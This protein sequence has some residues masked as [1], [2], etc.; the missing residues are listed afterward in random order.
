MVRHRF[1]Y[2][3]RSDGNDATPP[4][5]QHGR[6]D[7]LSDID[8]APQLGSICFVPALL[9]CLVDSITKRNWGTPGIENEDVQTAKFTFYRRCKAVDIGAYEHTPSNGQHLYAL[10][11]LDFTSYCLQFLRRACKQDDIHA[12]GRQR[13][14]DVLTHAIA[15][16]G[17]QG[18]LALDCEVHERTTT[19]SP[20]TLNWCGM[21]SETHSI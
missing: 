2:G 17:D 1:F 12:F 5:L 14:R 21:S 18:Y 13:S 10:R 8:G 7:S 3:C 4:A 6:H 20:S 15:R 19:S 11:L 9:I 16:A